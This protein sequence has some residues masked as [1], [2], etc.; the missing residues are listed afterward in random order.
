MRKLVI[1]KLKYDELQVLK[2]YFEHSI[3]NTKIDFEDPDISTVFAVIAEFYVKI[4]QMLMFVDKSKLHSLK[5]TPSQAI[6]IIAYTK[7]FN[8]SDD[9]SLAIILPI[10]TTLIKQLS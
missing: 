6:A 8:I 2:Q 4:T 3:V 5:L 9:Y 10:K 1:K 7:Y